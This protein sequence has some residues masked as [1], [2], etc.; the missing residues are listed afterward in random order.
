M[1]LTIVEVFILILKHATA[2]QLSNTPKEALTQAGLDYQKANID[3]KIERYLK[4]LTVYDTVKSFADFIM[5]TNIG[6][7]IRAHILQQYLISQN[8][9][10]MRPL[11][12][13]V[14]RGQFL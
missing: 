3:L 5:A 6:M 12:V 4:T 11:V 14:F 8:S 10:I 9:C 2:L 13:T 7:F 1:Y